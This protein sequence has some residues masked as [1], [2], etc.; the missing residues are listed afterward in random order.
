MLVF[1]ALYYIKRCQYQRA[2]Q[3]EPYLTRDEFM[4]RRKL[5]AADLF[6]EEEERRQYMIRKSLAS[7]STS[8]VGSRLSA[9]ADQIDRELL[10]MERRESRRLKEDW[11]AWEARERQARSTSGVQHPAVASPPNDVPILAIPSP[12]KHRSQGRMQLMNPSRGPP[13]PPPRHPG[14]QAPG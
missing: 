5:S 10:E 11:K 12:A 2:R 8:S 14:R 1:I 3:L 9:M 13:T 4:R 6:R 7:R